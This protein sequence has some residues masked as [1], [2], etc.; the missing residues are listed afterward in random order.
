MSNL[1]DKRQ[2]F[3][4]NARIDGVLG[5]EESAELEAILESSAE[6]RALDAEY[7][8]MAR[9]IESQPELDPPEGLAGLIM[10]QAV[11]P[12]SQPPGHP[13]RFFEFF[14]PATAGLAFAAGLLVT[15][16]AYELVPIQGAV[17][18]TKNLVGAM[19]A[20]HEAPAFEALERLS[21]D[22]PGLSGSIEMLRADEILQLNFEIET[23]Q[24][25]EV[26]L[27]FADAGLDFSGL[28][29]KA[30]SGKI[31]DGV[32]SVRNGT[33]RVENLGQEAFSVFLTDAVDAGDRGEEIKVGLYSRERLVFSGV[34]NK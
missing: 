2:A 9:L 20:N 19:V 23:E 31:P 3:L 26:V 14:Q 1:P 27:G 29:R 21:I 7:R 17:T 34:F 5:P 32:Y 24:R 11:L 28:S 25:I 12:E 33:F 10:Q 30:A 15:V 16:A 18:D 8:E 22:E 4:L 13:K 6:A